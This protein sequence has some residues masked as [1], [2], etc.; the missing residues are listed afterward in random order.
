M[1]RVDYEKMFSEF[2]RILVSRGL[3]ED[4]AEIAAKIFADN[5]LDGIYSHGYIRFLRV[6]SYMDAGEIELE[7]EASCVASFGAMERWEG[8]RG[9]GPLNAN[10]AMSRACEISEKFGIGIVALGNS[11]HWMRGGNYAW[12]AADLGKISISWSNTMP[13]MPAWGGKNCKIGN[14]PIVMGIPRVNG[15]HIVLDSALSQFSYG[16]LEEARL[17]GKQL[18]VPGG[19]DS[20]GNLTTDPG[21]IEQ[22][23]QILPMGYWKGS[24]ISI[25]LDLIATILSAGN[26][27]GDIGKFENEV[28]LSQVFIAID[29]KKFSTADEVEEIIEKI[30][31]DIKSSVPVEESTGVYYPGERSLMTRRENTANGIPVIDEVWKQIIKL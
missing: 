22:T 5:S 3:K 2:K 26:S 14:N 15:E 18:S 11:N 27:V 25:A 6:I 4:R 28:G 17:K 12:Q 29:P 9:F 20:E 8:Y 24:G 13:N 31:A 7:K 16:K 19:Y 1:Q 10:L 23:M 30:I 21:E